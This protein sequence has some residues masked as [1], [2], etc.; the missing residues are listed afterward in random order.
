M[1][2]IETQPNLPIK[3]PA[4]KMIK[5]CNNFGGLHSSR[6]FKNMRQTI[7]IIVLV[8]L[9]SL[10]YGQEKVIFH[11]YTPT[12]SGWDIIRWNLSD[13]TNV[14]WTLKE[15]ADEKGRVK[16]LDFLKNGDLIDDCLCYLAN[17]VTYEY[18]IGQIIERLYQGDQELLATDCEIPSKSIYHLDSQNFILKIE[19]FS[20]YDFSGMDSTEIKKWKEWVPEYEVQTPDSSQLQVDYYYHSFAKMNGIYPVSRNYKLANDYYYGDE[21]EKTSI[22]NGLNK[23]K[24]NR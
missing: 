23:L 20:K 18:S 4:E 9:T 7:A 19:T 24:N 8:Y 21:P 15:T 14:I 3:Y 13:T 22:I 11:E 1:N 17:R 5:R 16:E 6:L 12:A 10:A 2:S